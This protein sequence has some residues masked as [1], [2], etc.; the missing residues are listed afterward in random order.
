MLFTTI[1]V[2]FNVRRQQLSSL[3][4]TYHEDR[5]FEN[6]LSN[7]RARTIREMSQLD[8]RVNR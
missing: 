8:D 1:E 6:V 7:L 4:I 3:Q 5:F 2:I